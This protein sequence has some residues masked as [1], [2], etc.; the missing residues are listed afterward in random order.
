MVS[1]EDVIKALKGVED[2][3]LKIDIYTLELKLIMLYNI[4]TE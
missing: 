1:K 2:P 4:Y 3:E